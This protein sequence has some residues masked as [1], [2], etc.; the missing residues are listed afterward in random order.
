MNEPLVSILVGFYNTEKYLAEAIESVLAQ[1]YTNWEL[2]L[3]DDGA[4]DQSPAIARSYARQY[5]D[6][7]FYHQ[8]ADKANHGV[9]ASRNLAVK[10]ARG[11]YLA[12]L[13]SDDVWLADKL[14]EQLKIMQAHPQAGLLCEASEYWF[15]WEESSR[16]DI[17]IPVGAEEGLYPAEELLS[18]LYPLGPGAA[19]CPSGILLKA[20]A[21]RAVGGF[22][23]VFIGPIQFYEDQAFLVKLYS[24]FPVYISAG[25]HNRYRQRSGSQMDEVESKR[26]LQARQYFLRW[27][28]AYW[29]EKGMCTERHARL[30]AE[31]WL[32]YKHPLR[33]KLREKIRRVQHKLFSSKAA[34]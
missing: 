19:P 5:P 18:V 8:H 7:I 10:L 11:N 17:V 15:S 33:Y 4:T 9:A 21:V 31:A 14:A 24:Q 27:I 30:L 29:K 16:K 6:K 20:E 32:P 23:P 13:D 28:E 34:F 26:Y 3:I 25:V 2:L 12:V 22:E 1:T